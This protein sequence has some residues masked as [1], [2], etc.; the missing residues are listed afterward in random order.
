MW[1]FSVFLG[2]LGLLVLAIAVPRSAIAQLSESYRNGQP[3][4]ADASTGLVWA[5]VFAPALYGPGGPN[6]SASTWVQSLNSG[7]YAGYADWR[8][9]TIGELARLFGEVAV[10]GSLAPFEN[11][12]S[13]ITLFW[14]NSPSGP[15]P[16]FYFLDAG[17]AGAVSGNANIIYFSGTAAYTTGTTGALAVR[18]AEIPPTCS[19]Q[20]SSTGTFAAVEIPPARND[21]GNAWSGIPPL[22]LALNG[23][24]AVTGGIYESGLNPHLFLFSK[25]ITTDLGAD[26]GVCS[27]NAGAVGYGINADDEIVG[28]NCGGTDSSTLLFDLP[29]LGASTVE[30]LNASLFNPSA[31]GGYGR[32][33][34]T[35]GQLVGYGLAQDEAPCPAGY[36]YHPFLY[37]PMTGA[38][39]LITSIMAIG[40]GDCS[41][42]ALAINDAGQSAGYFYDGGSSP[43]G[44]LYSPTSG[45]IDL[46]NL[47]Y[48]FTFAYGINSVGDVTGS[49]ATAGGTVS[50]PF[51]Y[52]SKSGKMIDLGK[53]GQGNAIN[54]SDQ[55]TGFTSALGSQ[56]A[57]L[58]NSGASMM[59]LNTLVAA[60][61]G[62]LDTNPADTS[63]VGQVLPCTLTNGVA[64][65]DAGQILVQGCF[66]FNSS[67][68]CVNSYNGNIS[69]TVTFLLSPPAAALTASVGSVAV[70]ASNNYVVTLV[71]A[72]MGGA[73]ANSTA[74]TGSSLVVVQNGRAMTIPVSTLPAGETNLAPGATSSLTLAF[75]PL[76]GTLGA[77]AALRWSANYSNGSA[78]GTIR[79]ALP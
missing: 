75:P 74:L 64:I 51:L 6:P 22:G 78:S 40:P 36:G 32:A 67:P 38:Q 41:A 8:L 19:G 18:G 7:S 79:L 49:S 14:S 77:Q 44:F 20:T 25:G 50:D 71:L 55:V 27:S 58:Y 12:N 21:N 31:L 11:L 56:H 1:R 10:N 69:P 3:V 34:N 61:G 45:A 4:V 63:E 53:P 2:W 30:L 17:T 62:C 52:Q 54:A 16:G 65:N 70:G 5:D 28:T 33:I 59:D 68:G 29:L 15:G 9:P 72:N 23:C 13:A 42:L 60:S 57:F 48:Q 66:N 73:P 43:H 26:N 76:A 35:A 46:G 24:G 39:D 37:D 47:G